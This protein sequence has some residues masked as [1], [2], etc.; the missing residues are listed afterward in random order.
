[1]VGVVTGVEVAEVWVEVAGV[2]LEVVAPAVVGPAE[3]E[4]EE[5]G[6]FPTQLESAME[7]IISGHKTKWNDSTHDRS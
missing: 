1:M 5:V 3:P 4:P 6:F 2:P 7:K